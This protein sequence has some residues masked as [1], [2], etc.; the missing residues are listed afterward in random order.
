M[1]VSKRLRYEILRRDGHTCRYCGARAPDVKLAV[2]AVIPDALGGSHKD[3]ANLVTACE[4]C[5]S[6]KT[7]SHPDAPL[8][9]D[10]ADDAL[11][12]ARAITAAAARMQAEL[13]QQQETYRQVDEWWGN[14]RYADNQPVPRPPGWRASVDG[15][16]AA[17]L[18]LDM[19]QWCIDTAMASKAALDSKWRYMCGIAWKKVAGLQQAARETL[20]AGLDDPAADGA[21]TKDAA[22][23][24]WCRS[25]LSQR[26]PD[27]V[28]AASR[29][30]FARTGESDPA[31]VL[32]FVI[33][34]LE[35]DRETLCD[36][37]RDEQLNDQRPLAGI[38]T[39]SGAD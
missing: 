5:N 1:A 12:W 9:A 4:P 26:D 18:P 31:S 2:D 29:E 28:R 37:L 3:P 8:V 6:G 33:R 17:G 36:A 15:F 32:W 11:R 35:G 39:T 30:C 38:E 25:V 20:E 27:D 23:Q 34:E 7:S 10:V 19:L 13:S 21:D 22:L 16:L 14:W 24:D